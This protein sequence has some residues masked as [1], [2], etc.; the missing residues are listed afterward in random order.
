ME[1][2]L[3]PAG[4]SRLRRLIHDDP[5]E[6]IVGME[7][8]GSR[9]TNIST[10]NS[11]LQRGSVGDLMSRTT[12]PWGAFRKTILDNLAFFALMLSM[13]NKG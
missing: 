13:S 6:M 9:L 12:V 1:G 11:S 7:G 10:G 2:H 3:Q 4:V 8:A 5:Q